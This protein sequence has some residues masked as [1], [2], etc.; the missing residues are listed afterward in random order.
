MTF[1]LDP[2]QTDVT[3]SLSAVSFDQIYGVKHTAWRMRPLGTICFSDTFYRNKSCLTPS[4]LTSNNH[5]L[6]GIS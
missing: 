5:M 1:D 2:T 3:P 4:S 6:L